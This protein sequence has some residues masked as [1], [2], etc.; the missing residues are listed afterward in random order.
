MT[1]TV[2]ALILLSLSLDAQTLRGLITGR[3]APSAV[4]KVTSVETGATRETRADAEGHFA[5]PSLPVGRYNVGVT[6]AGHE[7]LTQA[8][9]LGV[10]QELEIEMP[11]VP[12]GQRQQVEVR[13]VASPLRTEPAAG[14]WIANQQ[15]V[16]LPLDGRNYYELSLLLPGVVPSAQG[17]AGSV[18]GDFAVNVNGSREDGNMFLLDG[19]YN[20]D[21]KLNGIG[22][23]SPVDGIREFQVSTANYDASFGRN[24]G[25]QVNVVLKS[26][27]N[28]VHGAAYYF[29]RNDN[30]DARNFFAPA[31]QPDPR[32]QRSQYGFSVGGP[33]VKDRTFFFGDFEGRRSNEGLPRL[34]R[35]PGALERTGDFSQS[36]VPYVI[37]PFTQQ[38]FPG[39]KIPSFR[40]DPAGRNIAAL[41]PAPNR[42]NPAQNYVSAPVQRDHSDNFDVRL[43]HRLTARDELT[44]RYSFSDRDL[45]EPF[46]GASFAQFP[47]FGS[48][49]PRRA[50]NA[51]LGY[52]R[53]FT[54]ALINELRLGYN[55]VA[56]G[57]FQQNQA[58]DLNAQ[59]GLPKLSSNARDYG[60]THTSLIGYSPIGDEYN[61]PQASTSNT[62][63]IAN[64]MTWSRG[65]SLWKFGGEM[66]KFD[67]RAYRDVQSRG[68]LNFVG[69]TGEALAD[70]LLGFPYASGGAVL[71]NPQHLRGESYGA[72]AQLDHRLRDSFTLSLGLR[73]EFNSPPVDPNNRA[74]VYNPLT[75]SLTQVGANGVPR[76]GYKSDRNNFGPRIGFAWS[77]GD[78]KTVLRGGYGMYFDQSSLAP[79]EGMYF[80]P[81]YF[82][83]RL[84]VT[85][86]YYTLTLR[87]PF[88]SDYPFQIPGSAFAF[89]PNIRTPYV[90][91][92]NMQAQRQLSGSTVVEVGYVGS[93]GTRLYMARDINQPAPGTLP[94]GLR[95]DPR[96]D[97][98]NQLESSANSTWHSLQASLRRSLSQGV[99]L[100]ASYTYGKSIDN[101]SGFFP[102]AGDANFPQD[103]RN[104]RAEKARSNFDARQRF[105]AGFSWLIP[106]PMK[107]RAR[108]ILAGWQTNGIVTLQSGRP[109]TV[110]LPSELDN[111]GTGRSSLGF[112]SND[113]PNV[114]GATSLDSRTPE[115]WFNTSAFAFPTPGTLGNAGR[116]ILDGPGLASVN[117]SVMKNFNVRDA[118][119]VQVRAETFN[120]LNRTNFNQ[121]Q[122]F[123]GGAGFGSIASAQNPRLVQLGL[124]VLF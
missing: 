88:P 100:I 106:C 32:Y 7:P 104:T 77:P 1:R 60:L 99:S 109:F 95:P 30:L 78:R 83:F 28:N 111:S 8:V 79:S 45:F 53:V 121:P 37:D 19:V 102:S 61:N 56:I 115:R 25:G 63:Q 66:R 65:R 62:Y 12:S 44:G 48:N 43:D 24:A 124:K 80:T 116:N 2:F 13:D 73:Y 35:V 5:V 33:V 85:S 3:T 17:S 74:N 9:T 112:G 92:W 110:A 49:V 107:S 22:L 54:P 50:Q 47:G 4:V 6:A 70:L 16:D 21:P 98:V 10:S 64:T 39:N 117:F 23:T 119:T 103:S 31:G 36:G 113:R 97:D 15:I 75:D 67:Q 29:L 55:R 86:Q 120:A 68:F 123:M 11:L 18:R 72:F 51:V 93:K 27:S 87:N 84:F 76:A 90:Q 89:N 34:T 46:T 58:T 41:Y 42:A 101:A 59:V 40:L 105:T 96:F 94:F 118:A 26:G 82:N 71:D 20:G 81:P 91:H 52:T 14:G 38:P 108:W 114:V 122:N 69:I 57:V